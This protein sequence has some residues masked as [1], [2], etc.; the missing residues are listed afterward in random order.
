MR[1]AVAFGV[2]YAVVIFLVRVAQSELAESGTYM[3]AILSGAPDVNAITLSLARLHHE[4]SLATDVAGRAV[5]LAAISN[6]FLKLGLAMFLGS[7]LFKRSVLTAL[8]AM[9]ATGIV[10]LFT[11]L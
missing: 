9:I 8:G 5:I 4:G 10:C 3:V 6:G 1:S 2:L 11:I 7:S